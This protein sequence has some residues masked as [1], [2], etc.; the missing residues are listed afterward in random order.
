MNN[1]Q[2][3]MNWYVLH[4]VTIPEEKL[5]AWL[6]SYNDDREQLLF[7]TYFSLTYEYVWRYQHR[8]YMEEKPLFPGYIF[9]ITNHPDE[10][11]K[12][13]KELPPFV[14][15]RTEPEEGKNYFYHMTEE[16]AEFL[17]SL[18]ESNEDGDFC[19]HRSFC[20]R[21]GSM[22]TQAY[23]ALEKHMQDIVKADY[24]K[25]RVIIETKLFG[26]RRTIKLCIYD[27]NDCRVEGIS[28][29]IHYKGNTVSI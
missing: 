11:Y 12:K 28:V 9:L 6:K 13:L 2:T 24:K 18:V 23:G 17:Y 3:G 21:E 5:L 16:D 4:T 1:I 22:I 19:V 27:E 7:E 8:S 20:I 10:L 15:L 25:R 14:R 26:Q 29:P